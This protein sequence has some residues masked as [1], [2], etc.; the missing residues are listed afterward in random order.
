MIQDRGRCY[1]VGNRS[2]Q[3]KRLP[4]TEAI[5][6]CGFGAFLGQELE[7]LGASS[8]PSAEFYHACSAE[9]TRI[10]WISIGID[11]GASEKFVSCLMGP[12]SMPHVPGRAGTICRGYAGSFLTS[13]IGYCRGFHAV[14]PNTWLRHAKG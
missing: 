10:L 11:A 9:D 3:K 8:E 1:L 5:A 4:M 12:V 7:E 13:S 6:L 2:P 14:L